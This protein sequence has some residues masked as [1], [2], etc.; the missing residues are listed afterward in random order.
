V[1]VLRVHMRA[2]VAE[3][4]VAAVVVV[5]QLVVETDIVAIFSRKCFH[6]IND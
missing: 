4:D 6:R 5:A 2:A 3:V 1:D